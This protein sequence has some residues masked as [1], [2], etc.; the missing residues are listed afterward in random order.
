MDFKKLSAF[1]K[2]FVS[3]FDL[4]GM[5]FMRFSDLSNGFARDG[6]MLKSDWQIVG[7]D[8]R[9]AISQFSHER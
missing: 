8:L 3:A 4:S 2:G 7:N 9:S 6:H 5:T 1:L